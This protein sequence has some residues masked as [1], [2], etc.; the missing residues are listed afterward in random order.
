MEAVGRLA[1]GV[2]HDFNNL[3]TV[4]LGHCRRS[5]L[6]RLADDDPAARRR[7]TRSDR[8]RERA[9]DAHPPAAGLQPQ[10]G[11]AAAGARPQRAV[12]AE[13][14]AMLRRLIGED[15]ELVVARRRRRG[16]VRADP[17]QI[18]QVL[19]NLAVNARDAMPD[20]GTL[21]IE[22]ANGRARRGRSPATRAGCRPGPYVDAAVSRHRHRH[23]RGDARRASSSRSSPPRR[24]G[25]GTGLGLSTCYGIVKQSG[26]TIWV[27]SE[28]GHGTTF[29][30]LPA[31]RRTRPPARRGPTALPTPAPARGPRDG[32]RW[33]RTSRRVR[34]AG[35]A[36]SSSAPATRCSS[37]PR[38]DE[39]LALAPTPRRARSTC[40][41]PTSSCPA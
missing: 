34:G 13:L 23:G 10:A 2:A 41:S 38:R 11:P 21:T 16:R 33:S 1:G 6:R 24:T 22:T 36:R 30:M 19:M 18:E 28:P 5:L 25:K 31:A 39:A 8:P 35:A 40:C 27:D 26:G 7:W 9:A 32:A 37:A 17:G 4:I 14:R 20:G 3:L 29:K 12:V 15:I